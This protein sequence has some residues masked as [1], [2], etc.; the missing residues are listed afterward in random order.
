[1]DTAFAEELKGHVDDLLAS[2]GA[3]GAHDRA[4]GA[5][6]RPA[7]SARAQPSPHDSDRCRF[8]VAIV[9][10]GHVPAVDRTVRRERRVIGFVGLGSRHAPSAGHLALDTVERSRSR[11]DA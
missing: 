3:P 2:A 8:D 6:A 4:G 7:D 10:S 5:V 11:E 1:M 9:R